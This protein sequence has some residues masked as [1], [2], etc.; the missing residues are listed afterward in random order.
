MP[1]AGCRSQ[2]HDLPR[3]LAPPPD[4]SADANV[5]L[6]LALWPGPQTRAKLQARRDAWRWGMDAAPVAP[7]R[8]HLTLHFI[9][10][11]ARE[12]LPGIATGLQVPARSGSLD[13]GEDALWPHG[14][15]VLEPRTP[16]AA[17]LEL[18]AALGAALQRLGLPLEVRP[19]RP[20]VTLAQH[21]AGSVAPAEPFAW[22]WPVRSY[23]LVE[24]Q[25]GPNATYRVLQRYTLQGATG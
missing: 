19:F 10:A 7:E 23:A 1:D 21:A 3:S 12:R 18:H 4:V 22:R 15:A 5:R 11:V 16:P 17:L 14:I 20:H 2:R 24:S 8:L 9:G 6:F 25:L 13:F